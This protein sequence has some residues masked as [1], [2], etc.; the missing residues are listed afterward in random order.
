M[1]TIYLASRE[2]NYDNYSYDEDDYDDD[3]SYDDDD[4]VIEIL[5]K[6]FKII[7]ACVIPISSMHLYRSV[8]RAGCVGIGDAYVL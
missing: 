7:I 4:E 1:E 6:C 3:F 8:H 5:I 2:D